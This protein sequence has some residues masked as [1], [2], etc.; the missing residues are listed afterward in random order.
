LQEIKE[1]IYANS[2]DDILATSVTREG[3]TKGYFYAKNQLGSIVGI[4]DD[5]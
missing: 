4:T 1:N 2:L 5:A 3:K